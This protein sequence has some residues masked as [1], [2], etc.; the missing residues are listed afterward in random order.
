[1]VRPV[2]APICPYCRETSVLWSKSDRI[3][4]RDY[5]PVYVCWNFPECDAYV[6]CHPGTTKP[7]GRLANRELREAKKRAHA[8][9]DP[10]WRAKIQFGHRK[11]AARGAAYKWLAAQLGIAFEDCHIGMFDVAQ[12]EAVVKLCKPFVEK[13]GGLRGPGEKF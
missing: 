9:F 2:S 6:G 13:M 4:R 7:L 12:C 10:L 8:H 3:Y 1:M 5:G 11:K